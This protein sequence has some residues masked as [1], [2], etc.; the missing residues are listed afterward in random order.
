MAGKTIGSALKSAITDMASGT[1][2]DTLKSVVKGG[3][4]DVVRNKAGRA[5][6]GSLARDTF[7]RSA[8]HGAGISNFFT[9]RELRGGLIGGAALAGAAIMGGAGSGALGETQLRT[10]TASDL[11]NPFGQ[12]TQLALATKRS[13]AEGAI[14]PSIAAG[15][16][17]APSERTGSAAPSLNATGDMVFGMHNGRRGG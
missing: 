12:G 16:T 5:V 17:V 7:T 14:N 4:Q 2:E 15:G 9:G 1:A 8:K 3:A 10:Q 11:Q 13:P 6:A